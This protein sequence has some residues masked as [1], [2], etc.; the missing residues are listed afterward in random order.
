MKQ[1]IR[2]LLPEPLLLGYHA[3]HSWLQA[4]RYDFPSKKLHV[5]GVTGTKGK[6]STS[7]FI[8]SV[9]RA[10]GYKTGLLSTALLSDGGEAQTNAFHMTMLGASHIHK[11]LREMLKNGCTHVV[12][13]TSSEGL[14]QYRHV[15]LTYDTAVFT[16]LTPEHLPSHK[17][18]FELYK[19]TKGRLFAS[20]ISHTKKIAGVRVPSCIVA[21]S[22]SE[23]AD[24]FLSFNAEKKITT[25]INNTKANVVATAIEPT[26]KGA[27]FIVDG[28]TYHLSVPGVFNVSN[29]LLALAVGRS[30]GL[31][32]EQI[33]RGLTATTLIPGRMELIDEGQPFTVYV[34]YAHE[35]ESMNVALHAARSMTKHNGRV[36]VL[37][38]AEGGG[39][40]PRKRPLMGERAGTLADIVV[41]SNVDPYEDDPTEIA[42]DIAKA[43]ELAGKVRGQNLFVVEDREKGIAHC[44]EIA[45]PGDVVLLTGK[46]AEQSI[47]VYGKTSPWDDRVVTRKL[48]RQRSY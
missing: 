41:V 44:L 6:T 20:L 31:S 3:V 8:W 4:F 39:R 15:G 40:D 30:E 18:S 47:C 10:G 45:A 37:L 36:I 43:S 42:E 1:V 38:G 9:L 12:I 19:T 34:D 13:E 23:H 35:R 5:I 27:S 7:V 33:D 17:N 25:G 16:N 21:N 28:D 24:F 48:L 22:D 14:K 32:P 26:E 2:R 46:G 11:K 29:A